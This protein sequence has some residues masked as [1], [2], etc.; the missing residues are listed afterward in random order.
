MQIYIVL[1]QFD[2]KIWV[3]NLFFML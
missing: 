1:K 2:M 3:T